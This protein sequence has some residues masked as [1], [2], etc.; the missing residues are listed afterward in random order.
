M[1][2]DIC[3]L[4]LPPLPHCVYLSQS[5]VEVMPTQ[6]CRPLSTHCLSH[7]ASH[8]LMIRLKHL[9]IHPTVCVS[10]LPEFI[11]SFIRPCVHA[12]QQLLSSQLL[13]IMAVSMCVQDCLHALGPHCSVFRI[14]PS[15]PCS[16]FMT[17][18]P[19]PAAPVLL[20]SCFTDCLSVLL[21]PQMLFPIHNLTN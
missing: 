8:D 7:V 20:P 21:S 9:I 11:H 5:E 19:L 14:L 18:T 16:C 10:V 3:V 2:I 17:R 6:P 15:A 1:N 13:P 12:L 4:V